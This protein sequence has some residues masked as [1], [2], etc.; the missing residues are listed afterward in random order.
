MISEIRELARQNKEDIA[1][2]NMTVIG[3]KEDVN[4]L[5]SKVIRN[6]SKIDKINERLKAVK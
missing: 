3:V 2:L 4:F 1:E 5:A 6:D